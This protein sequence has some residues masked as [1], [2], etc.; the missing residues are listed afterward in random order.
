[1][2]RTRQHGSAQNAAYT[3]A[4]ATYDTQAKAMLANRQMLAPVLQRVVPN[5]VTSVWRK[6][7]IIASTAN[8]KSARFPLLQARQIAGVGVPQ[9]TS[10]AAR[11]KTACLAKAG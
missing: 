6:S 2:R 9:N 7:K 5:S 1:M 11:R 8:R 4:D 10:E 3:K